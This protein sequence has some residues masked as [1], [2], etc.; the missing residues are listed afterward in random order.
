[1]GGVGVGGVV[2]GAAVVGV[3]L[4]PPPEQL[5]RMGNTLRASRTD[6]LAWVNVK[7]NSNWHG[8]SV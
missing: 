8:R 1:M 7:A 2:I 5:K 3:L 4:P 6:R